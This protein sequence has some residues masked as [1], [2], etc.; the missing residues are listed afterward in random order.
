MWWKTRTFEQEILQLN[1]ICQN[2]AVILKIVWLNLFAL[3]YE[4]IYSDLLFNEMNEK[5]SDQY[6]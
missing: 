5:F 4:S 6:F 1:S 2:I 3:Q